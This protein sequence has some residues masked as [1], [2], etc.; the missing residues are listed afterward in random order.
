[1]LPQRDEQAL[2]TLPPYLLS[3]TDLKPLVPSAESSLCLSSEKVLVP[4]LCL[5]LSNPIDYI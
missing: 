5:T 4:Q 1:M 2:C 3:S